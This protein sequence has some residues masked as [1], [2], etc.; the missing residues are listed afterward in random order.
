MFVVS[1]EVGAQSVEPAKLPVPVPDLVKALIDVLKDADAEVRINSANALAAIGSPA[2]D[3]LTAALV[4]PNR[5][6]RAAAAYAL[7]QMGSEGVP[8]VAALVKAL[9]DAETEVRRQAAQALGR[10]LLANRAPAGVVPPVLAPP[11][12]LLP[13][14]VFPPEKPVP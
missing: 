3:S 8:A 5:D 14:P 2:I 13:P 10:I 12:P 11:T 7:G 9:Q 4:G 1:S 6:A